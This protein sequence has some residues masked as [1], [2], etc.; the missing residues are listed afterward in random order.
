MRIDRQYS[1]MKKQ[2]VWLFFVE[3]G[4]GGIM[5]IENET[6]LGMY[7]MMTVDE[8]LVMIRSFEEMPIH[9]CAFSFSPVG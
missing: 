3:D 4:F 2:P 9:Y 7:V 1:R 6:Y 5:L 8:M